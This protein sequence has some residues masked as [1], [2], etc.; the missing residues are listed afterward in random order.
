MLWIKLI[1]FQ[2]KSITFGKLQLIKCFFFHIFSKNSHVANYYTKQVE[3]SWGVY[4]FWLIFCEIFSDNNQSQTL[5]YGLIQC[6]NRSRSYILKLII[7]QNIDFYIIR[8]MEPGLIKTVFAWILILEAL[9]NFKFH[10]DIFW[11]G[12]L[13]YSNERFG[14]V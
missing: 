4:C 11:G 5:I 2:Q 3:W 9:I 8:Y 14:K 1:A 7:F 13:C 6:I 12:Q 10:K